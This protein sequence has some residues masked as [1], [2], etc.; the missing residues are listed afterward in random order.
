MPN[1]VD[2]LDVNEFLAS[3]IMHAYKRH[4]KTLY[5][6]TNH[7]FFTLISVYYEGTLR[8]CCDNGTVSLIKSVFKLFVP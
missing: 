8:V 3:S 4:Y 2:N 5:K 1:T 6:M 7:I